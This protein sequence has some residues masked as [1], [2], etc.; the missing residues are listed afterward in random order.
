MAR[1]KLGAI[2]SM[3][4][5]IM[6]LARPNRRRSSGKGALRELVESFH[7]IHRYQPPITD[8][9]GRVKS[10]GTR[11]PRVSSVVWDRIVQSGRDAQEAAKRAA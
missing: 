6:S 4:A 2:A 11:S 8:R 7:P 10:R 5:G 3:V 1:H 9:L